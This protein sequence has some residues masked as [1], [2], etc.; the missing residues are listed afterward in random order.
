MNH[1]ALYLGIAAALV[2]SCSIQEEDYKVPEQDDV[3]FYAS[4]EQPSEETR[5]YANE[6]LYLRWTADDRVSIFNKIT[7]NQQYKFLGETGDNS[8]GFNRVDAAE[9][10]TGNEIPHVVSVYPYQE[11]TKISEEE[12]LTLTLPAEQHYVENTFGLG[13]NTMVSV[14]EDNVL[15]YKNVGGYLRLSLYGEGVTVSSISLKGNNGEK[16]AGKATVTMPLDGV[17]TVSLANDATD[18]IT[19]VCDI[20]IALGATSEESKDFWF[21]IPPVMFSKG[22]TIFITQANGGVF[23]KATSKSITIERSNLSKMSV[24]EVER[25]LPSGNIAFADVIAKYACVEKF[26]T[27]GDGELSYSE[28]AVV[29]SLNGLFSNWNTVSSFDEIRYFTSVTSTVGVFENLSK[30]TSITIPDN[31]TSLGTF[32]GCSALQSVILPSQLATLPSSCFD[33]C[34]S[35]SSVV[36]PTTITAIPLYCFQNCSS[37]RTID[38]PQSLTHIASY[39][40]RG[41][42]ALSDIV[43]PSSLINI[44]SYAFENCI[45]IESMVFPDSV[46]LVSKYAFSGCTGLLTISFGSETKIGEYAF[47]RCS[48]LVSVVLPSHLTVISEGLFQNCRALK[49]IIWPASLLYIQKNAFYG[50]TIAYENE[51]SKIELP[52]SVTSIGSQAF[53]GAKHI[54]IPSLSAVSIANDSFTGGHTLIYVP[55]DMLEMYKIRTNWS[56]Y[57]G[58]IYP[59]DSFPATISFA[60]ADAIDLGLSVK[61]ASWN[62]GATT[63][64]GYGYHYAWGETTVHWSDSGYES[65][66]KWSDYSKYNTKTAYGPVDNNTELDPEDDAAHVN[67][68]GNWRMPTREE[69]TELMENCTWTWVTENGVAGYEGISKLN[70]NRIFFPAAGYRYVS[71]PTYAGNSGMYWSSSLHT[72]YPNNAWK[73]DFSSDGYRITYFYRFCCKSIRAVT[74]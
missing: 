16:F 64:E 38:L 33:G 29:T 41:C 34:I 59:L 37:I 32:K 53:Y 5:V 57:V 54:I 28:A 48:S 55:Q 62:V 56:E 27:D 19:L 2:A 23:E 60:V 44:D 42:S 65:N 26:D 1:I 11:G 58:Q 52:A 3:I 66:Y 8:G 35:L 70:N 30:L 10:V 7:Y 71:N 49:S 18:E 61:W 72:D 12:V 13:A 36:L 14:S 6:N 68:G 31:I 47:S 24:M 20:P 22:F 4:F 50:A 17:P 69:W 74:D 43:F 25:A 39:A 46:S 67:W 40:F 15:Q 45:A 9:F 73:M 21:V 63:P 51:E